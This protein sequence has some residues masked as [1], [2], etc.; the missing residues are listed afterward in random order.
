MYNNKT[1]SYIGADVKTAADWRQFISGGRNKTSRTAANNTVVRLTDGGVAIKLHDTDI[2]TIN[3]NGRIG[4]NSGGW[5]S[6]TTKERI[7]RYTPARISQKNGIWYMGDGSIFYDGMIIGLDG[8]PVKPKS[9]GKTAAY[10]RKLKAIK[11]DAREYAKG[12]VEA[13]KAGNI[14]NPNGGDCWHCALRDDNGT[15][16]GDRT[17]GGDHLRQHIRDKYYVPSLL[18]NAGRAAGYRDEQIGLMGIGGRR[19]FIDPERNIYKYITKQ[20]QKE[21]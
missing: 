18:I 21:L 5:L 4:L 1:Q 7:K 6:V 13:L 15:A 14:D 3:D 10:E 11:K 16:L 8:L 19:L 17:G 2:V 9:P 20:L 12:F